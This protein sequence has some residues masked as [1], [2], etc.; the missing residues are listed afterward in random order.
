MVM[1][2]ER[3]PMMIMLPAFMRTGI[4]TNIAYVAVMLIYNSFDDPW[5]DAPMI[6][7][8]MHRAPG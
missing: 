4:E 8:V 5:S 2:V 6:M 7:M 1:T 3:P